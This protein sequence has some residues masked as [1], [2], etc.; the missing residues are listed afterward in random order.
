MDVA[1]AVEVFLLDPEGA[2]NLAIVLHPVPERP[3]MRFEIV[4]APGSPALEFALSADMQVGAVEECRFGQVV[5]A[6]WP[7][8]E[9][10]S[11]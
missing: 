6:I 8:F 7:W 3:I 2:A 1:H 4:A 11:P 5:H 9:G 10:F